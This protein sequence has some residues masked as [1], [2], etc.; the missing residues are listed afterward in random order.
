MPMLAFAGH[1]DDSTEAEDTQYSN[2]YVQES[3]KS[4]YTAQGEAPDDGWISIPEGSEYPNLNDADWNALDSA[5]Y[6]EWAET[7]EPENSWWLI[8][9]IN[10]W[11]ESSGMEE[12]F[13]E[14][15]FGEEPFGEE[16]YGEESY[17]EE[18]FE[19]YPEW[20]SENEPVAFPP[21]PLLPAGEEFGVE[22]FP[23]PIEEPNKPEPKP[24]PKVVSFHPKITPVGKSKLLSN[25]NGGVAGFVVRYDIPEKFRKKY[26]EKTGWIV[27][28]V[29]A[30]I[31][32]TDCNDKKM[33]VK[34]ASGYGYDPTSYYPFWEG[35]EFTN[36]LRTWL[37]ARNANGTNH[38]AQD[39]FGFEP[40]TGPPHKG[41]V[42]IIGEVKGLVG[43][44]LPPDMK[45]RKQ[46]HPSNGLPATNIEPDFWA[47][48][49]KG[50]LHFLKVTGWSSC[51]N[52]LKKPKIDEWPKWQK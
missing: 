1:T 43:V 18:P 37:G 40:F 21:A 52:Q 14:E 2:H 5:K 12:P 16:P 51:P 24:E 45:P 10:Y 29:D 38:T 30:T 27:Q 42:S 8:E 31:T 6:N 9:L 20:T 50:A 19:E 7:N 41:T 28:K 22:F 4:F 3:I 46:P 15:P 33:G 25:H 47:L 44:Q 36:D 23:E 13:G 49:D 48:S 11:I 17:G 26:S 32:V 39:W 34:E 35:W